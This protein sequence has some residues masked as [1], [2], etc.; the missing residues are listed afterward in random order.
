MNA[1]GAIHSVN[2]FLPL[3]RAGTAKKIV[4][5]GTEGGQTEFVWKL[6]VSGMAAY[7]AT[8]ASEEIIMTKYAALLEPEGF[9]V[10]AISP[11]VVD[12]SSTAVEKRKS[13]FPILSMVR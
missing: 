7:G 3:L 1:L 8:K 12:T 5:I 6:R 2:A 13:R 9:T 11:G 4:I 10:V